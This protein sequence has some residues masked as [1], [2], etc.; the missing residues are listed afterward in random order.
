MFIRTDLALEIKESIS[1]EINGVEKEEIKNGDIKTTKIKIT[2]KEGERELNRK[3]GSYITVEFP[4]LFK[5][6]D[7]EELKETIKKELENLCPQNLKTVLVAGLGNTDITPDAVGP[8][9]ANKILATRHIVGSFA[10]NMGL[11]GLKSV[12]T[13]SPG[14]LGQTGIEVT[15]LILGA[16]ETVKPDL[17]IVIDAL[18]SSSPERLFRTVQ[19]CDTGISP[20]SGVKNSRK[21]VSRETIG[22]PVVAV[23]VPT[24][25]DADVLAYC[26][27][28][29]ESNSQND[30]FVT[31]KEVDML[32]EKISEILSAVLNVFLQPNIDEE[33]LLSLV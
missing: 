18:A 3:I 6:A 11:K 22:V 21:E 19:L 4:S 31:P 1:G 9:T 23:G 15:E 20:G 29:K 7:Y 25:V 24:V 26:L 2:S 27:T 5:I 33:V 8:F 28:G 14:V 32:T 13:V 30:M 17:V 10:E 12:S 16:V